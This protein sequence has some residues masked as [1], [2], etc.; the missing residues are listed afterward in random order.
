MPYKVK[1][2]V[3]EVTNHKCGLLWKPWVYVNRFYL[4]Y[5]GMSIICKRHI[6]QIE[7]NKVNMYPSFMVIYVFE[8]IKQN[9]LN[10]FSASNP[11][12]NERTKIAAATIVLKFYVSIICFQFHSTS[13]IYV[14]TSTLK[15]YGIKT[16]IH[17]SIFIWCGAAIK[18]KHLRLV[19][20]YLSTSILLTCTS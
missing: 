10:N 11:P 4:P 6:H 16:L 9:L 13:F 5:D 1:T 15:I 12:Y 17:Q 14:N 20:C 19:I 2:E 3:F 8:M 7:V 18:N